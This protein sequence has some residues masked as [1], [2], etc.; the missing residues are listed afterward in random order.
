MWDTWELFVL[1]LQ[2]LYKF[3]Y[4]MYYTQYLCTIVYLKLKASCPKLKPY[5]VSLKA[6]F[7]HYQ[8]SHLCQKTRCIPD[9]FSF[10]CSFK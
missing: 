8:L 4:L 1:Y 7:S 5:H 10:S 9:S 3:T 2:F 6:I